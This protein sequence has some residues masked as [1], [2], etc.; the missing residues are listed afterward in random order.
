[1]GWR[2]AIRKLELSASL[3]DKVLMEEWSVPRRKLDETDI[4]NAEAVASEPV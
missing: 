2:L 3:L 1:M 4:T